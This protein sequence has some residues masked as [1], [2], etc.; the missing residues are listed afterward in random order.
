[1]EPGFAL[2]EESSA[3]DVTRSHSGV[4]RQGRLDRGG[5]PIKAVVW[6]TV[7]GVSVLGWVLLLWAVLAW[8]F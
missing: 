6:L 2:C 3:D 4:D 1:M 8:F 5:D 7:A